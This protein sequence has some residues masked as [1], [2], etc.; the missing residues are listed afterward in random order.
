MIINIILNKNINNIIKMFLY[1]YI[2]IIYNFYLYQCKF[3]SLAK[4]CIVI[5]KQNFK[6]I[7]ILQEVIK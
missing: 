4:F 7:A 2:K 1:K 3:Y 6:Y 5:L